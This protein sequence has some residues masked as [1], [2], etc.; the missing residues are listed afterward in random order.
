[1][2]LPNL[3]NHKT[4]FEARNLWLMKKFGRISYAQDELKVANS[5]NYVENEVFGGL[6]NSK[7]R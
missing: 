2:R 5:I 7:I 4:L 1:M 3:N 6:G